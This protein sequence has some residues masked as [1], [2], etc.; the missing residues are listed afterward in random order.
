MLKAVYEFSLKWRFK[1]NYDK[2]NIVVFYNKKIPDPIYEI[3][4]NVYV[5][6]IILSVLTLLK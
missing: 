3:V 2:C 6:V 1:F 5:E 4:N